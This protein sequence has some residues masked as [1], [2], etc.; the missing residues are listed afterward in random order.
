MG[1]LRFFSCH[2]LHFV[3]SIIL[4][5]VVNQA[6]PDSLD[7]CPPV[8]SEHPVTWKNKMR[9]RALRKLDQFL[10]WGTSEKLRSFA[11]NTPLE[12]EIFEIDIPEM[13]EFVARYG[14]FSPDRPIVGKVSSDVEDLEAVRCVLQALFKKGDEEL[15]YLSL[16][17]AELLSKVLAY[18]DLK[19][20]QSV[21]IPVV[22]N[23]QVRDEDFIVDQVFNLWH[24][25]P[26]FGL[27]PKNQEVESILLFRGTDFSLVTQRGWASLM[28]D[29]DMTGPGLSAFHHAQLEIHEWLKK[30]KEK[31]K[32]AK[33]MGFSLGGALAAYT[34]I[35]EHELVANGSMIFC[36]PGVADK[37]LDD[38]MLLPLEKRRGLTTYVNEG[39]IISKVG[40]LL[41]EA[42]VL[43]AQNPLKPLS[44]HTAIM[45]A[46]PIFSKT[47]MNLS[48]ENAQR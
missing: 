34:F 23:A 27:L 7:V 24:G 22:V 45:S 9:L 20:G 8:S 19:I 31:G 3:L 4:T 37:V 41:G 46:K 44:A 15:D 40:K 33:V 29:L 47:R 36:P 12:R 26:A 11:L 32:Q 38:W 28:S 43:A 35:Y 1:L 18:R 5:L 21:Q 48:K 10:S 16:A 30:A 17:S 42:F 39:D 2:R 25:M 13:K 14:Y 6:Y